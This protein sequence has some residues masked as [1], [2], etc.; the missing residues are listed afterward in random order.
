MRKAEARNV[1]SL[2]KAGSRAE[3]GESLIH[4]GP[5]HDIDAGGRVRNIFA[6]SDVVR[7]YRGRGRRRQMIVVI[8]LTA[9]VFIYLVYALIHPERF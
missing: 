4:D 7:P 6:V 8:M 2:Q 1:R 5:F 9:F 3:K